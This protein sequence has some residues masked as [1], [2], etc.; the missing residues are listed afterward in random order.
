MSEI[1]SRTEAG[2]RVKAWKQEGRQV[3]LTNGVFDILH[4][5]HVRYLEAARAKGD[6][7]V[8]GLNSDRSVKELK[9]AER[10]LNPAEERA[11]I[12]AALRCVDLVVI[13][14]ERTASDL[15]IALEPDIYA[16]GGDYRPESLPE[17]PAV[18]QIGGRIEIVPFV[19]GRSTT[20]LIEKIQRK[21]P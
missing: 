17:S 3:V 20:N 11:E 7:L 16:K 6:C 5:G 2:E 14:D 18:R 1:L 21:N 12:L 15:V 4:A 9:G 13:F 19:E 8:V 10:P